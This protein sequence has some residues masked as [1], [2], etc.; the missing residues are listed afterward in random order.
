MQHVGG[1]KIKEINGKAFG[2]GFAA[3]DGVK[4]GKKKDCV[5]KAACFLTEAALEEPVVTPPVVN[6]PGIY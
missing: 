5:E 1:G 6:K 3:L 4:S 2:F